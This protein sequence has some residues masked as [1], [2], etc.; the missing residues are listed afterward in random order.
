MRRRGTTGDAADS[1]LNTQYGLTLRHRSGRAVKCYGENDMNRKGR[2]Y[3]IGVIEVP[4]RSGLQWLLGAAIICQGSHA[5]D[6]VAKRARKYSTMLTTTVQVH[7]QSVGWSKEGGSGA[8]TI[9]QDA[10]IS[11]HQS[12]IVTHQQVLRTITFIACQ[13]HS[14][15]FNISTSSRS[16]CI[17]RIAH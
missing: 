15:D 2:R 3:L 11:R 4:G 6:N 1:E 12:S 10:G 5:S 16:P 13:Y 9:I 14:R 8:Y 17:A 7:V